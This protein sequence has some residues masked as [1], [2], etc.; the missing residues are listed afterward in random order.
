VELYRKIL[1]ATDRSAQMKKAVERAIKFGA[2]A[3]TK[4]MYVIDTIALR[5][6]RL[7]GA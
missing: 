4:H 5:S 2:S 7:K 1:I 6:F 3:S